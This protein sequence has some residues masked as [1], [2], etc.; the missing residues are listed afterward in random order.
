MSQD[1][2][3]LSEMT[4]MFSFPTVLSSDE[5]NSNFEGRGGQVQKIHAKI[6]CLV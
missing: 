3:L 6:L 2:L 4:Y 5:V 1:F